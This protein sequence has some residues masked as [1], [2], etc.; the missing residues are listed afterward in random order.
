MR[1]VVLFLDL[2]VSDLLSGPWDGTWEEN[3]RERDDEGNRG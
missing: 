3:K 2:L 1:K